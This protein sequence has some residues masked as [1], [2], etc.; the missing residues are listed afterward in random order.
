MT[1]TRFC[2][3]SAAPEKF[4]SAVGT[5]GVNGYQVL[6]E[7]PASLFTTGHE[8][9]I[10]TSGTVGRFV[11]TIQNPPNSTIFHEVVPYRGAGYPFG[12][13]VTS[14]A[15]R[16]S[17]VQPE[18]SRVPSG[19]PFFSM[20]RVAS[21]T[22][23]DV[24]QVL[25]RTYNP[26]GLFGPWEF[27]VHN[28]S[29]LVW[30]LT[31]MTS[32]GLRYVYAVQEITPAQV[33]PGTASS[34]GGG[35][36]LSGSNAG[37]STDWLV[38]WSGTLLPRNDTS[39][40]RLWAADGSGYL[41][42]N[43]LGCVRRGQVLQG[44]VEYQAGSQWP[45]GT[46]VLKTLA[47]SW[48]LD[49]YVQD[50]H[51]LTPHSGLINTGMLAVQKTADM[52]VFTATALPADGFWGESYPWDGSALSE[53]LSADFY[54]NSIVVASVDV[55]GNP[56]HWGTIMESDGVPQ[57]GG[58]PFHVHSRGLSVE[59]QT[60]HHCSNLGV[61]GGVNH[62]ALR[63]GRASFQAEPATL[64]D[65]GY[66]FVLA[67]KG[68]IGE[69]PTAPVFNGPGSEVPI[70]APRETS[71]SIAALPAL[72]FQ[73]SVATEIS[74][75]SP[76]RRVVTPTGYVESHPRQTKA[77]R[78][79]RFVYAALSATDS[80]TL[81]DWLADLPSNT[82]PGCFRWQPPWAL[83]EQAFGVVDEASILERDLGMG[84]SGPRGFEFEAIQLTEATP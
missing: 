57:Q 7:V 25:G 9:V 30:D 74:V 54:Y 35:T 11:S 15:F 3:L 36:H 52:K 44:G 53:D 20:H 82:Q 17:S 84:T 64:D 19:F 58:W 39:A 42:P 23:N 67:W 70:V 1:A 45:L 29:V 32:A 12:S 75:E 78:K 71:I 38:F 2:F 79:V 66:P 5:V 76:L 77:R 65:D 26:A 73:P 63:G 27:Q 14:Q 56:G 37:G 40:A 24:W 33:L 51:N 21:W 59:N 46:C 55:S 81:R 50:D 48:T 8:Y 62:V 18:C 31:A 60:R 69:I 28:L 47:S 83:T 41:K 80:T 4:C 43:K 6:H 49:T 34:P 61:N 68:V 13:L 22:A 72:P 16:C 10:I